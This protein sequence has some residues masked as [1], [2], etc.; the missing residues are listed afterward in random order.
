MSGNENNNLQLRDGDVLTIRQTQGWNDIAA[1]ATVRGEVQHPG[2][3]GIR[4]GERLSSVLERAGGF[5]PQA[6]PYGAVLM[7]REVREIEM[8]SHLA[9]VQRL[10]AEQV[11]LRA[12]PDT[13]VDQRNAKLTAIAQT[14][15]TLTQLEST[16]PVGRVVMHIQPDINR[17]RNTPADVALRDG[18]VLLIPKKENYVMVS[19]QVFNQTA[20]SYRPGRSATG[21]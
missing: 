10:K 7:R 2:S 12:L 11:N 4:P 20:I 14:E 3:Y 15:T 8:K 21:I 19:G 9:L 17:W 5:S 18:D 6:Y 13:D 1:S 16:A